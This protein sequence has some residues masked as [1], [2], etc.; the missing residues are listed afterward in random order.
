[1]LQW[2][3]A[4]VASPWGSIPTLHWA[5]PDAGSDSKDSRAATVD[6][7]L[8]DALSSAEDQLGA[9]LWNSNAAAL[10]YL[11]RTILEH[12][13]N[14]NK[15]IHNSRSGKN[16]SKISAAAC[17]R[18]AE[19]ELRGVRVV[20]LGAG[21]GCLGIALARAGADVIVTDLKE[22]V[23]LM[24]YNVRLNFGYHSHDHKKGGGVASAT[25][26]SS[27]GG[28]GSSS[29]KSE[30]IGSCA[31]LEWKWGPQ[32]NFSMKPLKKNLGLLV[33]CKAEAETEPILTETRT[34]LRELLR[35]MQ[36]PSAPMSRV[37][38][39][40]ASFPPGTRSECV[41]VNYVVLCDA[42]YGNPSDWSQLLFTLGEI[43]YYS[44]R[45]SSSSLLSSSSPCARGGATGLKRS[46]HTDDSGSGRHYCQIINFCE[47]RVRNVEDG[48]MAMLAAENDA[49]AG[50]QELGSDEDMV[51]AMVDHLQQSLFSGTDKKNNGSAKLRV[52]ELKESIFQQLMSFITR[53]RMGRGRRWKFDTK[54]LENEKSD[55]QM[56]IRVSCIT[57]EDCAHQKR[58]REE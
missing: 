58:R 18:A 32:G 2:C 10:S 22:L 14:N 50:G 49:V 39:T 19:G 25:E 33:E 5:V 42:L 37:R 6:N 55:L 36:E 45:S 8:A 46:R 41:A 26:T 23:P 56:N 27:S 38:E 1:M 12:L 34:L 51:N 29:A 57:W 48:F 4:P 21:V 28:G 31:A 24:E 11:R 30:R 47:Q 13:S 9:V 17:E 7:A 20:E 43:L 16:N 15:N 44:S 54:P 52:E 3:V 40:F 53:K 35:A